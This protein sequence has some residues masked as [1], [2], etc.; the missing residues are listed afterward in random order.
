MHFWLPVLM[1]EAFVLW[2]VGRAPK[3]DEV[4]DE[5]MGRALATIVVFAVLLIADVVAVVVRNW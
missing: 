5:A 4:A 2:L 1:V 3:G